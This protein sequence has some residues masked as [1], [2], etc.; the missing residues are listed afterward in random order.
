MVNEAQI[1]ARVAADL[2]QHSNVPSFQYSILALFHHSIIPSSEHPSVPFP[3]PS[4]QG[5]GGLGLCKTKPISRRS[6]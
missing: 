6:K 1:L 4:P 3:G 2:T 5:I